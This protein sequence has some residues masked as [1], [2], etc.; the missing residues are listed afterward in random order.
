MEELLHKKDEAEQEAY[1]GDYTG[2]CGPPDWTK[3]VLDW[4]A[5]EH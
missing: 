3:R 4:G 5:G 2:P 1:P